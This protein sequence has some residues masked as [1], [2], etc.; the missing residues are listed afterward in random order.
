MPGGRS[1]RIAAVVLAAGASR[2]LG[3]LKQLIRL[4][5]ETLV[6]RAVRVCREAGCEPV[7]V[8]LGASANLVRQSCV[9]GDA[10]VIVNEQWAD[11]MASS[12]RAGVRALEPDVEGC[13]IIACDQPAVTAQHLR[14]LI[15]SGDTTASEYVGRRGVPAY[16][17]AGMFPALMRL[18]GDAGAREMLKETRAV[19]LPGGE[20]D[21]DTPDDLARARELFG[22]HPV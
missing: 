10:L 17:P 3:E 14:D 19:K 18:Y 16:F 5:G 9:L 2:R 22:R 20:L 1:V 8:V 6:E 7:V 21:V 4:D 15:A 12:L 13:V 11:G